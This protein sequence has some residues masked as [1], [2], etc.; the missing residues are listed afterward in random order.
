[1]VTHLEKTCFEGIMMLQRFKIHCILVL[2]VHFGTPKEINHFSLV[3]INN[4]RI[5]HRK[6]FLKANFHIVMTKKI[7]NGFS[8]IVFAKFAIFGGKLVR[9][10]H[11]EM[12]RSWDHHN[13]VG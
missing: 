6:H 5:Y 7:A 11:I 8:R 9:S 1:M 12:L 13:K 10:C 3:S 2:G 4:S